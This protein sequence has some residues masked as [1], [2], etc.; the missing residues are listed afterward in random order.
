MKKRLVSTY[1]YAEND[2]FTKKKV[3][4]NGLIEEKEWDYKKGQ[5]LKTKDNAGG[6][7]S[8]TK[9]NNGKI[10]TTS[11]KMNENQTMDKKSIFDKD[12]LIKFEQNGYAFNY[13]YDNWGNLSSIDCAGRNL[14]KYEYDKTNNKPLKNIYGNGTTIELLYD[15]KDNLAGRKI[16]GE[17]KYEYKYNSM[18]EV[19]KK[20]DHENNRTTDL[21][22]DFSG[23]KGS[24]IDTDGTSRIY[25]FDL[26]NNISE[27]NKKQFN[28]EDK[29]TF[30]YN[31]DNRLTD[32][33]YYESETII[34]EQKNEYDVLG[35]INKTVTM[36]KEKEIIKSEYNY[37]KSFSGENESVLIDQEV[38]NGEEIK[39]TYDLKENLK[40]IASGNFIANYNYDLA[41]QLVQEEDSK[42]GEVIDYTYDTGG[43]IINKKRTSISG[44][45][46][47]T[48]TYDSVWKDLL[49]D[50]DGRAITYDEIS[51][52]LTFG[53]V[54]HTWSQGRRLESYSNNNNKY[55]YKYDDAGVRSKKING[56]NVTDYITDEGKVLAE[57]TG[58]DVIVYNRDSTGQLVSMKKN[59]KSYYYKLNY[60]KDV[61]G[62]IDETGNE[63]V[64]YHY[65]GG[66]NILGIDG[67]LKD[68]IGKENPFRYRSYYYDNELGYYYLQNRYYNPEINRFINSDESLVDNGNIFAY[69][70]NNP[71]LSEDS[72]GTFF[73]SIIRK[74]VLWIVNQVIKRLPT[75]IGKIVGRTI[76]G[77]FTDPFYSQ[78]IKNNVGS[79]FNSLTGNIYGNKQPSITLPPMGPNNKIYS[80]YPDNTIQA[81]YISRKEWEYKQYELYVTNL[82]FAGY[83]IKSSWWMEIARIG[84]GD[85]EKK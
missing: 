55:E 12:K 18:R 69:C 58:D 21:K 39:Y 59:D 50:Y 79:R 3:N 38:I 41:N 51:N 47:F 33:K 48:Y 24:L 57:K 29:V 25:K 82:N 4:P 46:N 76:F 8:F 67:D 7:I 54:V 37:A 73:T 6:E 77:I 68:T 66:G 10:S 43:N 64:T 61:I 62:L 5:I 83:E 84:I 34:S 20:I 42:I 26:N 23:R 30:A 16:N 36:D 40:S 9:D 75:T 19:V 52:M 11:L 65:D 27:I 31:G 1:E 81:I 49:I 70:S 2:N 80:N 45:K 56:S 60:R 44:E 72:E 53:E 13:A 74:A 17:L 15:E 85:V 63:V 32:S 78:R 35:R 71:V 22:F 28:R 14:I